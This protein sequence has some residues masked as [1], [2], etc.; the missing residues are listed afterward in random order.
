MQCL[1]CSTETED[2]RFYLNVLL[3]E[4]CADQA[5]LLRNRGKSE[6]ENIL[7]TLDEVIRTA[8]VNSTGV[9]LD[10]VEKLTPQE[11]VTYVLALSRHWRKTEPDATQT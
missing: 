10:N 7:A 11:V 2:P 4:E 5:Q 1:N 3:C 8:L 6:L 9:D